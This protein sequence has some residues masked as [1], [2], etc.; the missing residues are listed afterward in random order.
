MHYQ[1][2]RRNIKEIAKELGVDMILTGSVLRVE[3]RVRINAQLV[4]LPE[5]KSLWAESFDRNLKDVLALQAGVA[6]TVADQIR[7]TLTPQ[8]QNRLSSISKVDPET[9]ERYLQGKFF[10]NQLT[11][12]GLEK[13][14]DYFHRALARNAN[15]AEAQSGV[16]YG[17]T[18]LASLYLS[19]KATMPKAREA[20]L[21]AR[22]LN[23]SLAE[24]HVWLGMIHLIYF[25]WD[26]T[27]AERELKRA[28]ELNPSSAAAHLLYEDLLTALG[29]REEAV[30]QANLALELDPLSVRMLV[31]A[32]FTNLLAGHNN[33]SIEIGN[34][35]AL[36][37]NKIGLGHIYTGLAYAQLKDNTRAIQELEVSVKLEPDNITAKGFLAHVRALAGDREGAHR[38]LNELKA[39]SARRYVC[40][41]E[42]GTAYAT[43]GE[44]DEAFR[45][46]EKGVRDRADCMIWMRREPW[47]QHLKSD[48]RFQQL[49]AKIGLP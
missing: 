35:L 46:L 47:L 32:Q 7:I 29:R 22:E 44:K 27:S 49:T 38:I 10:A 23:P 26:W 37:D 40:A 15:Y 9:Y 39:L 24:P 42:T 8:E 16:A 20:T 18:Q 43:L 48:P 36:I 33:R 28:L 30:E 13:G 6:R 25:D 21:K 14:I 17:Y 12:E 4:Q 1:S 45:W 19:P 41:F 2:D 11:Q 3:G 31:E 34:K 5:E